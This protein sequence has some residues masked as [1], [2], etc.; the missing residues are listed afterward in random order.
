MSTPKRDW[1]ELLIRSA[2][3]ILFLAMMMPDARTRWWLAMRLCQ[4]SARRIGTLAIA[5]E[6]HYRKEI[7]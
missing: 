6:N 5:A 1:V 3:A 7:A 4:E 2:P